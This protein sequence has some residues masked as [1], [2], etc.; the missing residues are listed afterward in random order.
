M[1]RP[2]RKGVNALVSPV[3]ISPRI[4]RINTNVREK[5]VKIRVIRGK[6]TSNVPLGDEG[7][8]T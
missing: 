1:S 4:A 8:C 2:I 5:L 7:N 3:V 6:N